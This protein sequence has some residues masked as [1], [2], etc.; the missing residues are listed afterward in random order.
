MLQAANS[1]DVGFMQRCIALAGCSVN[2]GEYPFAAVIARNGSFLCE[3][4][5]KVRREHDVNHHAEVAA[6]SKAQLARG[7]NLSD[8]TIYS[9]VEPCAQCSYAI[10]EAQIG[11]VVYGL[12]SSLMGGR[13]RW[14]ILSETHLSNVLPEVFL[15]ALLR[16]CRGCYR[17]RLKPS[18]RHGV[19]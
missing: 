10:R 8:C 4:I 11:T 9:A 17:V 3:S 12:K 19:P 5:N 18:S 15:L 7:A 6:I 14:N 2:E 13:S 16:S 1:L